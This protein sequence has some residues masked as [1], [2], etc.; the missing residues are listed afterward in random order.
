ALGELARRV[1]DLGVLRALQRLQA[2]ERLV[3]LAGA[4][5]LLGLAAGPLE[6]LAGLGERRL[7]GALLL[8][9]AARGRGLLLADAQA[10]HQRLRAR[11]DVLELGAG[12]RLDGGYGLRVLAGGGELLG[13]GAPLLEV[14]LRRGER[15]C[16]P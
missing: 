8:G 4:R 13:L 9:G 15:R 12:G 7:A 11:G 16:L 10:R 5:E 14:A 2:R 6:V 1:G 3:P